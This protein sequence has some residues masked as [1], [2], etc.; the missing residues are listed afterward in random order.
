MLDTLLVR[1]YKASN[2]RKSLSS[3]LIGGTMKLHK[4]LVAFFSMLGL[5]IVP[6]SLA[7]GDGFTLEQILSSPFPSD[8]IATQSGDRIAWVFDYLGKRNI[9]VAEAPAFK[10][11]QLTSYD[12]D[13]GQ[14]I[15]E[16]V[17]SPDGNWIAY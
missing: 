17:F 2:R 6:A 4:R 14:E 8:L 15:T 13:D 10:G 5:I 11:R 1:A 3:Q 16:T 7:R 9:W 12:R